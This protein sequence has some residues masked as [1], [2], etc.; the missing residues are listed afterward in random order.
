MEQKV[1]PGTVVDADKAVVQSQDLE[2][3][4]T[5]ETRVP[6]TGVKVPSPMVDRQQQRE[7][8]KEDKDAR[9]APCA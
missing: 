3:Q 9:K 7:I 5:P 4:P 2:H 6:N 1:P 8:E